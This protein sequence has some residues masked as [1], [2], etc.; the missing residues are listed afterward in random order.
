MKTQE[1][2]TKIAFIADFR[3]EVYLMKDEHSK[4]TFVN[5]RTLSIF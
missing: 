4:G 1:K 3:A 5:Q 2:Y